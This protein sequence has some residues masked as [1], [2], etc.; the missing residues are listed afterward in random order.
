METR[1]SRPGTGMPACGPESLAI[2]VGALATSPALGASF[3]RGDA[4]ESG[5][6]D[7]TDA[8]STIRH[9]FEPGP[10]AV[11]CLDAADA[12]DSGTIDLSDP[13][14]LLSALFRGGAPPPA[15]FPECGEDPS[16]DALGCEAFE[17]CYSTRIRAE[18]A[19]SRSAS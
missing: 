17:G 16:D 19:S 13:V 6:I 12:D 11:R 7:V 3:V 18:L 4:D 8:V 15:P 10:A 9:P 1:G 14:F 5:A 2:L